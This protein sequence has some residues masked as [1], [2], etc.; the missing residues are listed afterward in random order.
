ML[1]RGLDQI[2][3]WILAVVL[4]GLAVTGIYFATRWSASRHPLDADEPTEKA[5]EP[6]KPHLEGAQEGEEPDLGP[7]HE[8]PAA[9]KDAEAEP[10]KAPA[11]A[12]PNWDYKGSLGPEHWGE[13][14]DEFKTC[15]VGK[16]QSPIDIDEPVTN[17]KLLPIKT[18]AVGQ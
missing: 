2:T 14:A 16:R 12:G 6:G 4:T 9:A 18:L 15:K 17:G 13:L 8:I 3:A 1:K 7:A 5:P 11:H 10:V